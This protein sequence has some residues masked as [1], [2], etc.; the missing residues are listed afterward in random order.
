MKIFIRDKSVCENCKHKTCAMG[1]VVERTLFTRFKTE[2]YTCPVRY[3][4]LG[5]ADAQIDAGRIDCAASKGEDAGLQCIHCGLCALKCS[6]SNLEVVQEGVDMFGSF[7]ETTCP[8]N[9]GVANILAT[10]FLNVL[11]EFSA[12]TNLN[13][14]LLFDGIVSDKQG[15]YAFVEVDEGD[16]S[17]ESCRRLLGDIVQYNFENPKCKITAGLM[18]LRTIPKAGSRDVITLV[19]HLAKFPRTSM[20]D[21]YVI[22]FDILRTLALK[23]G[24][25]RFK[26]GD[27]LFNV[28]RECFADYVA[29]MRAFGISICD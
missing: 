7:L 22:T 3:L 6:C 11:F 14:A 20:I 16:D 28:S 9:V 15:R 12:N 1:D 5:P 2:R 10:S 26:F 24:Q 19:E 17:L 18:V 8:Q 4:Q 29:R 13:K 23:F 21:F 25:S 27:L